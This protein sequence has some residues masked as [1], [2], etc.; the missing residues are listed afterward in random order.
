MRHLIISL[1]F[2]TGTLGFVC[3]A[4]W[5]G[6]KNAE[7]TGIENKA[8]DLASAS[9]INPK[10]RVLVPS[11][12]KKTVPPDRKD[13]NDS[14]TLLESANLEAVLDKEHSAESDFLSDRTVSTLD[15]DAALAQL[16]R[17]DSWPPSH[18]R[19]EVESALWRQLGVAGG[20]RAMN[21]IVRDGD[22]ISKRAYSAALS[23]WAQQDPESCWTWIV[24]QNQRRGLGIYVNASIKN[25]HYKEVAARILSLDD[26][27]TQYRFISDIVSEWVQYEP[28]AVG[29]W[30]NEL[31]EGPIRLTSL[32]TYVAD[33]VENS[34]LEV[35]DWAVSIDDESIR[36]NSLEIAVQAWINSGDLNEAIDWIN[37]QSASPDT[38][39]AAYTI[40]MKIYE[41]DQDLGNALSNKIS[42]S[43]LYDRF[44][45]NRM[46]AEN[47][48]KAKD[49]NVLNNLRM[50]VSAAQRYILDTGIQSV[51]LNQ[52]VGNRDYISAVQRVQDE[53]YEEIVVTTNTTRISVTTSEGRVI[54]YDF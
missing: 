12:Q 36:S 15:F 54:S 9:Q 25:D 42:D 16:K 52:I 43:E 51:R 24:F 41:T 13:L 7:R 47:K 18:R 2:L 50:I 6:R 34:P 29:E 45:T 31:P 17:L 4:F 1:A 33:W 28:N 44:L 8:A 3:I 20:E 10:V 30:I 14:A 53:I 22:K 46:T 23:G 21:L 27:Y 39:M 40:A 5:F 49:R 38:D 19:D 32:Y 26:Q 35:A 11:I 48:T 37:R